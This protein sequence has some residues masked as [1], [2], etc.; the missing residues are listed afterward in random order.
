MKQNSSNK[1]TLLF[2]ADVFVT[3]VSNEADMWPISEEP[4][5]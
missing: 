4:S 2:F 5:A 3:V 1:I